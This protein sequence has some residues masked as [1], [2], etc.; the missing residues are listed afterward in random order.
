MSEN[1]SLQAVDKSHIHF[2]NVIAS[3]RQRQIL[4]IAIAST[5][6]ATLKK[7]FL[8]LNSGALVL[9]FGWFRLSY[10][11]MI[12]D[13]HITDSDLIFI[14]CVVTMIIMMP[15]LKMSLI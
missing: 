14:I 9:A 5:E 15:E 2:F 12:D 4:E 3:P 8:N 1:I 11:A 13:S 6:L 10:N 7:I